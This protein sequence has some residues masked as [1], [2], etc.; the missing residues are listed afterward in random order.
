M[1]AQNSQNQKGMVVESL[2]LTQYHE[3][4]TLYLRRFRRITLSGPIPTLGT[5]FIWPLTNHIEGSVHC[6]FPPDV[7]A[8]LTLWNISGGERMDEGWT[9]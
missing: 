8:F 4:C 3:M 1:S 9:R 5:V 7:E 2:T 6:A